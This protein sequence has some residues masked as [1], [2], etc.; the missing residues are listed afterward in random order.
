MAPT[1]LRL[2]PSDFAEITINRVILP[3]ATLES[4]DVVYCTADEMLVEILAPVHDTTQVPDHGLPVLYGQCLCLQLLHEVGKVRY[5][6]DTIVFLAY[7]SQYSHH[8]RMDN[9]AVKQGR[10]VR[11]FAYQPHYAFKLQSG[12][13]GSELN[14]QE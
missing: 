8:I 12:D 5:I 6:V 13:D 11:T 14:I 1:F 2:Q 9:P 3:R 4:R 7:A 10:G